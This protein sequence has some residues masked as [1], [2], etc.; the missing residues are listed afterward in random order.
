MFKDHPL[1]GVGYERNSLRT[2]E[3]NVK[4]FGEKGFSGHAHNHF[5]Q[6]LAGTGIL[7]FICFMGFISWFY[8]I[9]WQLWR[10]ASAG[11][12]LKAIGLGSLGA[13]TLFHLGGLTEAVFVDGEANH[14]YVY[15]VALTVVAMYKR[16]WQVKQGV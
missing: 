3:Y 5:I 11:T 2:Q 16:Q 7:G 4:V 9:A 12:E 1:L 10:S 13:Q 8:W 14:M 6:M 15:I